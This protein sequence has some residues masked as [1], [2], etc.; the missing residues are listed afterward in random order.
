[1]VCC[2]ALCCVVSWR[3]VPFRVMSCLV[4]LGCVVSV[5]S[6]QVSSGQIFSLSYLSFQTTLQRQ[7]S[8][9]EEFLH[10]LIVILG[11]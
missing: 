5:H 3:V 10:L 2:A 4:M 11:Q 1:M 9:A 7:L 6:E 8:L